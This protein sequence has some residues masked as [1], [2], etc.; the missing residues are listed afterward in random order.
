MSLR[1]S[2][3]TPESQFLNYPKVPAYSTEGNTE[4]WSV[5]S[6]SKVLRH[7]SSLQNP[8][9]LNG[10]VSDFQNPT[11]HSMLR[12]P[13]IF[14]WRLKRLKLT[15]L[16]KVEEGG[17][18][19]ISWTTKGRKEERAFLLLFLKLAP[20]KRSLQIWK[21]TRNLMLSLFQ[22]FFGRQNTSPWFVWQHRW[23]MF[24]S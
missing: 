12:L 2:G 14:R 23:Q 9:Q 21:W 24:S 4:I 3:Q 13:Q 19:K 6:L 16:E 18:K 22:E 8:S 5:C 1:V 11:P 7:V 10:L 15:P 17:M 20:D